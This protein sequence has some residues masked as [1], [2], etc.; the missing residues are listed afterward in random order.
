MT[1]YATA[2]LTA[3]CTLIV[4]IVVARYSSRRSAVFQAELLKNQDKRKALSEQ[5]KERCDVYELYLR[6]WRES[7]APGAGEAKEWE[8]EKAKLAAHTAARN[9]RV[10]ERLVLMARAH[11]AFDDIEVAEAI[12]TSLVYADQIGWQFVSDVS[13]P[14]I[15]VTEMNETHSKA[16]EAILARIS[17]SRAALG[18]PAVTTVKKIAVRIDSP[19]DLAT[20]EPDK[21]PAKGN[22]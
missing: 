7:Y 16:K 18:L 5:Y 22:N 6:Q 12:N 15:K 2:L 9:A 13:T 4:S 10:A 11:I 21:L 3:L 1:P 17:Q 14:A 20:K 19:K 8:S